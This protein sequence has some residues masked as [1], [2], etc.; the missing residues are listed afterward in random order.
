MSL[1][2]DINKIAHEPGASA[3]ELYVVV[4]QMYDELC[5]GEMNSSSGQAL[6]DELTVCDDKNKPTAHH[7]A[8]LLWDLAEWIDENSNY[9]K[10]EIKTLK[11]EIEKSLQR[12]KSEGWFPSKKVLSALYERKSGGRVIETQSIAII[13]DD[14]GLRLRANI[15]GFEA[16][17][18][19]LSR[20][21]D[22]EELLQYLPNKI[23][24]YELRDSH[25]A[26]CL[27]ENLESQL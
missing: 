16:F 20:H 23:G 27:S 10:S 25:I 3:T 7:F 12:L 17:N 2:L 8:H 9:A 22:L 4:K 14:P 24:E 15:S 11:P 19:L 13:D 18:G 5:R 6:S 26:W 21:A 1:E